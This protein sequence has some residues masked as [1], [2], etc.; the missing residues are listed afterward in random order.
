MNQANF[1]ETERE[2][3]AGR[4]PLGRL[5]LSVLSFTARAVDGLSRERC[6]GLVLLLG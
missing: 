3:S 6:L 1:I 2:L 4:G 5:Q